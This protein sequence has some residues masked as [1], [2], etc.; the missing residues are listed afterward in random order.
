MSHIKPVAHQKDPPDP[1][2]RDE[3]DLIAGRFDQIYPGQVANYVRFWLYTGVRTSELTGLQW[4]THRG[5]MSD[6]SISYQMRIF[7]GF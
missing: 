4:P 2:S 3:A 5:K 1:F 6:H 7:R